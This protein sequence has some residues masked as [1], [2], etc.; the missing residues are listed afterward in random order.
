MSKLR[1]QDGFDFGSVYGRG[2]GC[3]NGS[4]YGRG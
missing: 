2:G 3:C 4:G 1:K